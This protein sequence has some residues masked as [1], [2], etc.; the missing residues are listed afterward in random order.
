MNQYHEGD[1][2]PQLAT[3]THYSR[4]YV[5]GTNPNI[6]PTKNFDFRNIPKHYLGKVFRCYNNKNNNQ[7]VESLDE[8]SKLDEY[9]KRLRLQK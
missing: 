7:L 5:T 9:I 4:V 3:F 2:R 6:Y 1:E 8:R